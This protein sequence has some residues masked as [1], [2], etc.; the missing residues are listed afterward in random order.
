[1]HFLPFA[2][3]AIRTSCHS[4]FL[5]S[6]LPATC[7]SCIC[8]SRHLHTLLPLAFPAACTPCHSRLLS[9][10]PCHLHPLPLAFP[11]ARTLC[12]LLLP[13]VPTMCTSPPLPTSPAAPPLPLAPDSPPCEHPAA[14]TC[15]LRSP[16]IHILPATSS[17]GQ[18]TAVMPGLHPGATGHTLLPHHEE[19]PQRGAL[20]HDHHTRNTGQ[21]LTA[22]TG[23]PGTALGAPNE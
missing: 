19:S 9:S 7:T 14:H 3:H 13:P 4:H 8:S 1:M 23:T 16:A 20:A 11:A 18:I 21:Y 10:A 22:Q 5:P 17:A 15:I 2:L 12:H 6:A